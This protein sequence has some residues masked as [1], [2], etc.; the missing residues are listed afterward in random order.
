MAT[1]KYL[2]DNGLLYLWG[3]I[4]SLVTGSV[5]TKTSELTNDSGFITA[6][7]VPEGAQ[8]SS[9]SPKM[10][11]TASVGSETA[12]AR[13]DHRHPSDT[14]KQ[15]TISDL[16]TIRSGAA[17]G[18]TAYQKPSGGIPDTDL[19]ADVNAS[20]ALANSAI[21]SHQD[22]SG[23]AD[24]SA[25]VSTVTYNT[26]AK[27]ITKTINGSTTDVVTAAKI[28]T[29]GG[30]ITSHQDISG[31]APKASPAL[32]GTPTAPTAAAGTNTTQIATTAFVTSAVNT[33]VSSLY[34][35]KGTKATY[36]ALPTTGNVTGDVWNVTAAYGTYPAGTN[37][38]WN[39]EEWDALGGSI[40]LSGYVLQS[41]LA[42]I[43]NAEIDTIVAN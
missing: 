5:P 13:G 25:T 3:K 36:S 20:L 11:G 39:G 21:Q 1:K 4:K 27:K 33:A 9:T 29:D 12:F 26:T 15:D 40:D 7:D 30:G 19:S 18:A 6:D 10:D 28:V 22:I 38:V 8:A 2:D 35:V 42:T 23:K 41:D 37:W 43:T 32:S 14:S 34:K 31:L 24:K 17:A 16:A